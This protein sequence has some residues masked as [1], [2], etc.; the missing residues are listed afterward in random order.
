MTYHN[1]IPKRKENDTRTILRDF[2]I[3]IDHLISIRWPDLVIARKKKQK[4]KNS[5]IVD[6]A[7]LADYRVK[8]KER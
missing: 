2:E 8:R 5:Q 3:Q 7:V 4:K 6:F 1:T